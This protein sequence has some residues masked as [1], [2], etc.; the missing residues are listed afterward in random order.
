[1]RGNGNHSWGVRTST[2]PPP[3]TVTPK[4][5]GGAHGLPLDLHSLVVHNARIMSRL[6][7]EYFGTCPQNL[8]RVMN[9]VCLIAVHERTTPP[10]LAAGGRLL[11]REKMHEA[12]PLQEC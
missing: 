12:E 5:F 6:G 4:L 7:S 11:H 8:G 1:M 9:C 3:P 2:S 10:T